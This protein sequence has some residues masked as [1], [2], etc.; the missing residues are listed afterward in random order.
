MD[1]NII[2]SYIQSYGYLI[3]FLFLF[4]GIVGIPAP[5]ESLLFFLGILIARQQLLWEYCF[6]VSWCGATIGMITAY[7]VGRF[8]GQPFIKRYGKYVGIKAEKWERANQLFQKY[9][10]WVILFGYYVPGIRQISPYMSGVIQFPFGSFVLL[11]SIGAL[12]WVVPI[13]LVGML[14]GQH[15]HVPLFYLPL[16][17]IVFFLL[18]LLALW[19]KQLF[20]KKSFE[21]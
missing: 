5:E 13:M 19:L 15:V 21:N 10:K 1:T 2:F 6:V 16:I 9:G 12:L 20:S 14:L 18:F 8:L 7:G 3:I 4:F 17:G 11:A